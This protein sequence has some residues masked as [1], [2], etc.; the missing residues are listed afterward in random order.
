[1]NFVETPAART[2]CVRVAAVSLLLLG[3]P[4][5]AAH[6]DWLLGVYLGA[7]ATSS[8]TLTIT[9][10]I[11]PPASAGIIRYKGEAFRSPIYYGYRVGWMRG[12]HGLGAEVEFTHAKAIARDTGSLF[13][14]QFEQS[15]GLNFLL[16]NI[17]YRSPLACNGRCAVAVRGGAGI[18]TPH[19]ES[20]FRN[21]HQEQ[22]QYGGI[23]WQV[24]A[25]AEFRIW[26]FVYGIA[27]A[28]ITRVSEK[29]LRAAGA[30][31][32]GAF[33]TRHVDFGIGLRLPD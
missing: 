16:G 18:S 32:A 29:H 8:N 33:F 7:A 2:L 5:R 23:A 17:A 4:T 25:G 26:Q 21:T 28:R 30:E 9:P 27:D 22:Y 12:D 31:I 20:T 11:G 10:A 1:M 24:G 19:V 13:L 15:H 6:A 3:V 14:T